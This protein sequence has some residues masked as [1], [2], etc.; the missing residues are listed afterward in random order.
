MAVL[1]VGCWALFWGLFGTHELPKNG[2]KPSSQFSLLL[3]TDTSHNILIIISR[4]RDTENMSTRKMTDF[5]A[6]DI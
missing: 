5:Q 6:R 3:V 2:H 4:P 1:G